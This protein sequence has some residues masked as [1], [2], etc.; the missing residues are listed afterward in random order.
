MG[1]RVTLPDRFSPRAID[2]T[3]RRLADSDIAPDHLGSVAMKSLYRMLSVRYCS[4]ARFGFDHAGVTNLS[5]GLGIKGRLVQEQLD[6]LT[7]F[8]T[9]DVL[10][11][12]D[13]RE[14]R[15]VRHLIVV[16]DELG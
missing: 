12:T 5:T 13:E 7:L 11:F 3:V 15:P 2:R 4:R 1:P 6:D 9:I 14:D 8:G 16:A 10:A